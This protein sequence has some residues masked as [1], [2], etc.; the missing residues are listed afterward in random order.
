MSSTIDGSDQP[1][2][3]SSRRPGG[4]LGRLVSTL[5]FARGTVPY[6]REKIAPTGSTVAVFV[7]GDPILETPDNGRG[8]ALLATRGFL[9]GPHDGPVVNE[10]TGETFAVGIVG[11]PV[12]CEAVFGLAPSPLR[13]RVVD[14]I[15]AWAPAGSLRSELLSLSSSD[16]MLDAVE[17]SL[18]VSCSIPDGGFERCEAAV[19]L[20]ED[21]PMRPIATIASELDVSH[22]HLDH[23]FTRFVGLSPRMLARLL[24]MRRVL[25]ALDIRDDIVW[26]EIAARH[27]W[28]DQPHLIRDFKRHTGVTPSQYLAAQRGS[29]NGVQGSDA[30][31]FVPEQ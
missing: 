4:D 11:T 20:L 7:L 9:T 15:D 18:R 28:F 5:W 24:R 8:P 1:F 13:G 2:E 21:D 17:H 22:G 19:A 31:G 12:G 29:Y 27:G 10:P 3:F 26:S 23:E 6:E 16:D 30:A 14:L 25:A